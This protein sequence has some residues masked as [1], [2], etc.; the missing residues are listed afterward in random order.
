MQELQEFSSIQGDS[1]RIATLAAYAGVSI[2]L[3]WLGAISGAFLELDL[4]GDKWT[5][6]LLKD[7]HSPRRVAGMLIVYI[8]VCVPITW[9][10]YIVY[11]YT[12]GPGFLVSSVVAIFVAG[13]NHELH[14]KSR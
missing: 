3:F 5:T 1:Y 8:C 7:Q 6:S 12:S 14:L 9:T 4:A 10:T 13:V 2:V 11:F